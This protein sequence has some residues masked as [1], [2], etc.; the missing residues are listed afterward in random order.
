MASQD[1][2]A[3][4]IQNK[5]RGKQAKAK[6]AAKAAESTVGSVFE[7]FD[8]DKSG[9]LSALEFCAGIEV[10]LERAQTVEQKQAVQDFVATS[11]TLWNL[12]SQDAGWGADIPVAQLPHCTPELWKKY[13]DSNGDKDDAFLAYCGTFFKRAHQVRRRLLSAKIKQ[14]AQIRLESTKR[15]KGDLFDLIDTDASG[16]LSVG[17]MENT[18]RALKDEGVD[19]KPWMD[20]Q[21]DLYT[22]MSKSAGWGAMGALNPAQLPHLTRSVFEQHM[23]EKKVELAGFVTAVD[24]VMSKSAAIQAAAAQRMKVG[25]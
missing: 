10:I 4:K 2:A 19:T 20:V 25:L 18:L 21:T 11:S 9:K 24:A 12:M 7:L 1:Q 23:A 6:A 16:A 8:T 13:L 3:S 5:T 17:E 14:K 15:G 22:I